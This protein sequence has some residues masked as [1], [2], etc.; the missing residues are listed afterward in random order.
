MRTFTKDEIEKYYEYI[1]H[2]VGDE[3]SIAG[4]CT[5]CG[6]ELNAV[7]LPTGLE[8]KITCLDCREDFESSFKE[9]EDF[10]EI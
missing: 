8:K 3:E 1:V 7:D 5:T 10:G 6:R 9:L 4:K 2:L